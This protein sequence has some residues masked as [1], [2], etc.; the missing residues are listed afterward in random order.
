IYGLNRPDIGAVWGGSFPNASRSGFSFNFDTTTLGNGDHTLVV[1]LLDAAGNATLIG[2]RPFTSQNSV[3][4]ITT[5]NL[6]RGRK[7]ESYSQQL[8]A[9]NG[10]L[11]FTWAIISG[12][13]PAG[14]SLNA[15]GLIAG[16]PSVFGNF[17]FSVRAT[18][19]NNVPAVAS[20]TLTV[21]PDVE[22][23]RVVSNGDLTSGFTG[24]DY[25]HQLLYAG[26]RSPVRWSIVTGSL[27]PGLAL[28]GDTGVISGRPTT[29]GTFSFIARVIDSEFTAATSNPLNITIAL[30][31]LG[32]INTG[33]LAT[34]STGV[35]YSQQLVGT[36]GTAP[37]TW[38]LSNGA[39]PPGLSLGSAT[40][41]ITGKPTAV[42][43][44]VIIVR[45]TDSTSATANSDS[46]RIV[47]NAGPLV[48]V[49][50]GDL[51]G[52]AVNVDYTH[53][54]LGAG[55]TP[56]YTWNIASGALPSGLTLNS[57]TGIISGKPTTAGTFNFTVSLR[58]SL[59]TTVGS[60]ALR[61]TVT[62]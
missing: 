43:S 24:V 28:N 37:Y 3:F 62:P 45:I 33:N 14:V 52:G 30:G 48:V 20:Y 60:S 51:A 16:T 35:D 19:A 59:N 8:F 13:L 1:R 46:L 54:L 22:I 49:S 29:A 26:G 39:L 42:G 47:V 58:D 5:S 9:T 6:P 31:P 41:R 57:A 21:L 34:G 12:S 55:G 2:A 36:G 56:P 44:W 18:D 25:S 23:L 50:S 4:T 15:A 40:G 27:P 32:V 11:P 17:S 61:I 10:R 7:G 38:S 53:A